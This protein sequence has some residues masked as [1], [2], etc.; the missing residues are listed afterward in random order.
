MTTFIQRALAA[1][2][3]T[4]AA[5]GGALAQSEKVNVYQYAIDHPVAD[6]PLRSA[7]SLGASVPQNV[8]IIRVGNDEVYGYFYYDGRP[9]IVELATRSVVRIDN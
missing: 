3:L 8:E 7:P 6:A 4:L 2:L 9:V 5:G 1:L